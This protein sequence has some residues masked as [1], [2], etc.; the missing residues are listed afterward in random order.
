MPIEVE[1]TAAHK[2]PGQLAS[3]A[4]RA[5]ARVLARMGLSFEA[6][7]F[8]TQLHELAAGVAIGAVG[9]RHARTIAVEG[10]SRVW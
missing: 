2:A 5:G 6:W 8:S 4:F 1:N 10:G 3:S 9:V 7:L